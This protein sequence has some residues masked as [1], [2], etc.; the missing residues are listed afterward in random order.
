LPLEA[1]GPTLNQ[2]YARRQAH[3]VDVTPRI[4]IVESVEDDSEALE[5]VDVEL[6]IFDVRVVR[7]DFDVWVELSGGLLGNL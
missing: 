1:S 4:E 7:F 2:V 5:E 6:G 3:L